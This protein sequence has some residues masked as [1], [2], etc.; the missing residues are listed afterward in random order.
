LLGSVLPLHDVRDV[1][2]HVR[3]LLDA[4]LGEWGAHLD[5]SRYDDILT[6]LLGTSWT[7]S[8][9]DRLDGEQRACACGC[10][11]IVGWGFRVYTAPTI[12]D[13]EEGEA[14]FVG[15]FAQKTAAVAAGVLRLA[16]PTFLMSVEPSLRP[17]VFDP[18]LGLSFSTYSRRLLA[19]RAVDWYRSTFG[20]ARYGGAR[21]EVSLDEFYGV[22]EGDDH[23][24][25]AANDFADANA[26]VAF[27]D[28]LTYEALA[29]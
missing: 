27:D 13:F 16:S 28:T 19:L 14:E 4:R 23:P 9:V 17:G 6:Y 15:W 18:A 25:P 22:D 3:V 8:G 20:D 24:R 12:V 11:A 5:A 7:L 1:E 29:R 2:A 10:G 26:A 21:D